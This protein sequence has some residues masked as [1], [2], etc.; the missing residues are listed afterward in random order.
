MSPLVT[1][2]SSTLLKLNE[3]KPIA[4]VFSAHGEMSLMKS[5]QDG[6]FHTD[7]LDVESMTEPLGC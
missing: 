1:I 4:D 6:S 2:T 3:K 5:C 7:L